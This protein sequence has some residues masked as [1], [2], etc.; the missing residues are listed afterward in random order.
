MD[1]WQTALVGGFAGFLIYKLNEIAG[2]LLAANRFHADALTQTFRTADN[3][4]H[5]AELLE[6]QNKLLERLV[7]QRPPQ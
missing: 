3:V 1:L 5:I 4:D 2:F 7:E 6:E